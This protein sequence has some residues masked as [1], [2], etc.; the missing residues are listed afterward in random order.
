[1]RLFLVHKSRL[2]VIVQLSGG[3][4]NQLFQYATGFAMAKKNQSLL[5]LDLSSFSNYH[6]RKYELKHYAISAGT[7]KPFPGFV[8]KSANKLLPVVLRNKITFLPPY[9]L[10][11]IN[12]SSYHVDSTPY[13]NKHGIFLEGYW[14]S[15]KYFNDY[16]ITLCREFK[17]KYPFTG[18]NAEL[19]DILPSEN[20][21]S[22]HIRRGDYISNHVNKKIYSE[23][24]TEYYHHAIS[25]MS[26]K[27]DNPIFYIFSDDI[28][29]SKNNLRP[30]FPTSYIEH[31]N[32]DQGHLDLR[33]MSLC[34]HNIIANSSFSWWGA[35]LNENPGKIV[36]APAKWYNDPTLRS[37]D[38]IPENW[39]TL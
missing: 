31:N 4:G 6:L 12:E 7:I 29:W 22:I 32:T 15:E 26:K 25:F 38:L 34:K 28:A 11:I 9:G 33:L 3:L 20:S 5:K 10:R 36:I 1:M 27:V 30:D 13:Q 37:D 18:R 14:Q 39:L 8:Y 16:R 2:M 24:T 23:C 17:L 35:W 21:V 19:A